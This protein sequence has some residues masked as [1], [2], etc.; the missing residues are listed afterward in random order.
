MNYET[1]ANL[2]DKI[3]ESTHFSPKKKIKVWLE[4][5][6]F[7]LQKSTL[8]Q[9][10]LCQGSRKGFNDQNKLRINNERQSI[11]IFCDAFRVQLYILSSH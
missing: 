4:T 10:L 11:F 3:E 1:L 8:S 6:Q 9:V 5:P 7:L 2:S